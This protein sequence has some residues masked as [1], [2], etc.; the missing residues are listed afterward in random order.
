VSEDY[1]GNQGEWEMQ[2]NWRVWLVLFCLTIAGFPGSAHAQ[3][4]GSRTTPP[5]A[6]LG[7]PL[8]VETIVPSPPP[9]SASLPA[10]PSPIETIPAANAPVF[11]IA[12]AP[13]SDKAGGKTG[14]ESLSKKEVESIFKELQK[15]RDEDKSKAEAEKK[16]EA[17]EKRAYDLFGGTRFELQSLYDSLST[18]K[19]EGE[20][21]WYEKL[22]IRGY[23]QIRFTR[24][25]DQLPQGAEPNL[26]GDRSV[27]GNAENFSFRR[28]R[29]ILFGDVSEH[30]FV[31]IQPD[32]ASTPQ[33]ST[34]STFFGQL[35]DCYADVHLDTE[36]VHRLRIGLSKVPY[37][38][39]NLQSSQNRITLDRTDAMN[40]AVAP[41]E[42]DLGII[43]YWTPEEQQKLFKTLVDSGLKGSGNYGI[44]GIGMYDGQGGSVPEANLNL[45]TVSRL[46]LPVQLPSGQVVEGSIQGYMGE[47]TVAGSAIQPLG[48]GKAATPKNTGAGKNVRDQRCAASFIWYPQPL[49]FQAEWQTGRGPGLNPEQTAVVERALYGG[50]LMTMWRHDTESFGIF[51]PYCRYQQFQGGYRNL[52]NAP[53]GSQRQVDLGVEWQIR[54]E[55]ELTME[56]SKA[57]TPNF[58]ARSSGRSY[59]DFEGNI[60]RLQFQI[61]Y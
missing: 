43:Y 12:E 17:R 25:L 24:T 19:L 20:K 50:Y 54:K 60:F 10:T 55:M 30:L 38:F 56:F 3:A 53:Y 61:N 46:T 1:A 58:S 35:R 40:T 41:N 26:F 28:V 29:L 49:G 9:I 23:T 45:H 52:A 11:S 39:E 8:L 2:A 51:T 14:G 18:P 13:E 31:Y 5:R 6:A 21:K 33:G 4:P 15:K 7:Q 59:E 22:Q 34:T 36:K 32:F 27:N 16:E 44:F 57:N 48:K 42:R 47:Y 37:G